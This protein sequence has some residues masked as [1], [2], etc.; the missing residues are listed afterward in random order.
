MSRCRKTLA[1]DRMPI[2]SQAHLGSQ[3]SK[4]SSSVD[5]Y[6]VLQALVS[7]NAAS[8]FSENGAETFGG[9]PGG[10]QI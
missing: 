7:F 4:R 9:S 2:A 8:H 3:I 10:E 1:S 5:L 6:Q